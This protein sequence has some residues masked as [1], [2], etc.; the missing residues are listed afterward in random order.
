[1]KKLAVTGI[2]GKSGLFFLSEVLKNE[3][4]FL[5]RWKEIRFSSRECEKAEKIKSRVKKSEITFRP[6]IGDTTD[7][8]FCEKLCAGCDTLLH[9]AGI[10]SSRI[11]VE[12][13]IKAGVKRMILVHTTGIYSKYK[14]AGEEYRETDK[15]VYR[16]CAENQIILSILRPTMIYGTL[17]DG[18]VSVFIRM[19]DKLPVMPTVNGGRYELQPVH[20]RD[21]GAAYFR[22]LMNEEVCSG[23]DYILSGGEPIEL[24][25]MFEEIAQNL[26][27]KKHFISCPYPIAYAG[28]W[29]IYMLTL[30]KK[31]YREKVQRLVEP[32]IYGHEK[33]TQDFGYAPRTFQEGIID[34]VRMYT[35]QKE[36]S[37]Q[38][39]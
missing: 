3:G 20:C 2:T 10:H 36:R 17:N 4:I 23:N 7:S 35:R 5:D 25:R 37:C 8:V 9:I 38:K 31:D 33:A 1:M 19:I 21:L 6:F 16:L 24:R 22:V 14:A 18:N 34:E 27:K 30:G 12:A 39:K 26:E 29:F 11:M 15:I 13:A 28:A 32:R